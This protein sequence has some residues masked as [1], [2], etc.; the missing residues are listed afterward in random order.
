MILTLVARLT[1]SLMSGS[2][3]GQILRRHMSCSIPHSTFHIPLST[4]HSPHPQNSINML[5]ILFTS[6]FLMTALDRHRLRVAFFL[7]THPFRLPLICFCCCFC[8]CFFLYFASTGL[9]T[10]RVLSGRASS[11][12]NVI[13][14]YYHADHLLIPKP[15]NVS[16]YLWPC[17]TVKY[18]KRS[19]PLREF[20]Q[21]LFRSWRRESRS[22]I[23]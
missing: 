13:Q 14:F 22:P 7:R 18:G 19:G 21:L 23:R 3:F 8:F 12:S 6:Q 16:I 11:D 9:R 4:F 2:W 15:I 1:T 5:V 20:A 17:Y 10:A